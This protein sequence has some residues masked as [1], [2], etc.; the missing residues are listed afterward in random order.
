MEVRTREIVHPSRSDIF[1]ITPLGCI[2]YGGSDCAV[3][4]LKA[5]VRKIAQEPNHFWIGMGDYAECI[6][7]PDKRFDARDLDPATRLAE[8]HDLSNSQ[9]RKLAAILDP[10]RSRCLGLLSGNHEETMALRYF[11]DVHGRFCELM[12]NDFGPLD[13]TYSAILRLR[14]CRCRKNGAIPV[15]I[16]AHHGAGGGRKSGA[17][18]NRIEDMPLHFPRCHIYIMGHV[19][20]RDAGIRMALDIPD[21]SDTLIEVPRAWGITG[22]FKRTYQQG[23]R[24]YGEKGQMQPTSLGVITFLIR[25]AA[26]DLA[27]VITAYSSTDGLPG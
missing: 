14:F 15:R 6:G 19:H 10:I 9:L 12:S 18:I 1:K 3:D 27:P 25:P 4:L 7:P 17:I 26:N 24:G 23:G 2:H 13:L 22:T 21:K 11:A 16:W 8:L 5:C 20:R